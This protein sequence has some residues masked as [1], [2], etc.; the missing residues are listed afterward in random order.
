MTGYGQFCPVARAS[1]IFAERWTPLILRELMSERHHFNEILRGLHGCSPTLL[2][3]RLRR[4]ERA[5]VIEARPN[6]TGRGSTYYL[7]PS[8]T[9]LTEVVRAL[10][11]WGQYWLELEREH[12]DPDYL[13]WAIFTHLA[14]DALPARRQVVRFEFPKL[15]RTYWLILRRPDPDLCYS[16]PRFG[17]DVVVRGDVE[18]LVRVYLGQTD[19]RAARAAGLVELDGGRDAVAAV[20]RWFP[21]SGFAGFAQPVRFDRAQATFVRADRPI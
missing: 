5:D 16:D 13:M 12:I 9:Q 11:A 1:E 20:A 8:G 10:G 2:R 6:P 19:L 17:D 7:T 21:R 18:A 4:L 15:R 3:E 14:E